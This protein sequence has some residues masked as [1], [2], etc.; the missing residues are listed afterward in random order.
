MRLTPV[1]DGVMDDAVSYR[2]TGHRQIEVIQIPLATSV[3]SGEDRGP[4]T[5]PRD[6][7]ASRTVTYRSNATTAVRQLSD[8]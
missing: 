2:A 3:T 5:F 6:K 7:V 4:A 1:G 8:R